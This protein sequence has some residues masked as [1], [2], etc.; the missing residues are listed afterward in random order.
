MTQTTFF[1]RLAAEADKDFHFRIVEDD[2][3]KFCAAIGRLGYAIID[4]KE[5]E[6]LVAR[7]Q[8]QL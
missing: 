3:E 2:A 8:T 5:K 4:I 1:A 6:G 7:C